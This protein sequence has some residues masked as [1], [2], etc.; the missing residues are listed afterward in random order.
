MVEEVR[1]PTDI[2]FIDDECIEKKSE[3]KN[4]EKEKENEKKESKEKKEK[5]KE[6]KENI[7]KIFKAIVKFVDA[8]CEI[9]GDK[10]KKLKSYKLFLDKHNVNTDKFAINKHVKIFRDFYGRNGD[11]ILVD[12]STCIE[13]EE[14]RYSPKVVIE[15][16]E[17]WRESDEDTRS[18]IWDH[19]I[20]I[21][22]LIDPSI[23]SS[24]RLEKMRRTKSDKLSSR[25]N[26]PDSPAGS[27]MSKLIDGVAKNID[28][29]KANNP[30]EAL[31][32]LYSSG[33]VADIASNL[34]QD[35]SSG[36]MDMGGLLGT[37]SSMMKTISSDIEKKD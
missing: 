11:R 13:G 14:I 15:L 12:D 6:R 17:I 21:A 5:E 29:S 4:D 37:F 19:I 18:T 1:T 27:F 33:F 3:E 36:R 26:L 30:G 7:L 32:G 16:G 10:F 8:L 23:V 24:K 35:I 25:I 28:P 2:V 31:A 34:Q 20:A 22:I 9:F